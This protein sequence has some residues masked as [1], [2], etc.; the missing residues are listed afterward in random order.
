M[1]QNSQVLNFLSVCVYILVLAIR[2]EK[3]VFSKQHRTIM[4]GLSNSI[5]FFPRYPKNG[6]ILEKSALNRRCGF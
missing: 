1:N 5:I 6:K 2:H 3:R 4:C